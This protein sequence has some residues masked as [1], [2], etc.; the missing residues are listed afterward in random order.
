MLTEKLYKAQAEAHSSAALGSE[1]RRRVAE[2]WQ[3][4]DTTDYW[5]HDRMRNL[6]VPILRPGESWITFGDGRFGTD[7]AWLQKHG[8][9]AMCT[10]IQDE[11]L[12]MAKARGYIAAFCRAN[13]EALPFATNAFDWGLCKEAYHHMP[14]PAIAFYEMLRVARKGLVLIEPT[15]RQP[16]NLVGSLVLA[17]LARFYPERPQFEESGNYVYKLAIDDVQQM[18]LG[19][20]LRHFAFKGIVDCHIEGM[21]F[22]RPPGPLQRRGARRIWR[23]GLHRKLL[24]VHGNLGI[25]VIFK[26]EAIA[27]DAL[28]ASGFTVVDLPPNPYVG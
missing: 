11:L 3:R 20:G 27:A 10:D 19:V 16:R 8:Q 22:E 13:A 25:Y 14:R 9:Q 24:G 4:E 2:T 6:I 26:G 1:A 21:E 12:A 15:P 18:L 7:A 23:E 17:L 5:R 28:R